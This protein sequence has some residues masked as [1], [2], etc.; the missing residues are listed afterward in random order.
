[1]SGSG[2]LSL[3]SCSGLGIG[4]IL[5][6]GRPRLSTPHLFT[7]RLTHR[8]TVTLPFEGH[9]EHYMLVLMTQSCL[10][11]CGPMDC[12]PPGSSVHGILQ[13]EILEWLPFPSPGDLPDPGLKSGSPTL[14]MD[15]FFNL[16]SHQESP[17]GTLH[18]RVILPRLLARERSHMMVT[19]LSLFSL[20]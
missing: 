13:A 14:Q 3:G 12:S 11:L 16:L 6:R 8:G 15:F 4:L 10:T 7:E 9:W 1:M 5:V 17:W 2:I 20:K 19:N 18:K